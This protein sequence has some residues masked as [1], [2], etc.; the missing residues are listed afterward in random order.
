M[1]RLVLAASLFTLGACATNLTP[2]QEAE[3]AERIAEETFAN[4]VRRG[5]EVDRLCFA[6]QIDGFTNTTDRA[7][8]VSEGSREYLITTRRRCDN[9]D[10]AMSLGVGGTF[11]CLR[12]GDRIV[13]LQSIRG[14][15]FGGP[16]SVA[17]LVDKIYEWDRQADE[18][19]M[20]EDDA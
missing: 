4:D 5:E 15:N 10:N 7:V 3:R 16:P 1:F 12:R 14:D 20:T 13:G 11:S 2:E 19:E 17:C 18:T 8:V 9:L 6:S